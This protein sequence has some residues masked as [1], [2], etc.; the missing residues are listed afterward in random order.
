M[1][2]IICSHL[3]H[4]NRIRNKE[5]MVKIRKLVETG[6]EEQGCTGT[7]NM[8]R[9]KLA[10]N[11]QNRNCTDTSSKCTGTIHPKMPRMG[12]FSHFS[13]TLIH[14]SLLYFLHTSKSIQI[15]FVISFL[16]KSS[17]NFYLLSKPFHEFLPIPF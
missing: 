6:K 17:S 14:G 13:C 8:Y 7:S 3:N 12:I 2:S 16:F 5:V 10:K 11:D 4:S 15:H 9:Y 1:K